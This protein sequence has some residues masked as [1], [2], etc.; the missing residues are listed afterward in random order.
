MFANPL[1]AP[2]P[3]V[4]VCPNGNTWHTTW[5]PHTPRMGIYA[6]LPHVSLP[7]MRLSVM[8]V[9]ASSTGGPCC[10][11]QNQTR[12]TSDVRR[13]SLCNNVINSNPQVAAPSSHAPQQPGIAWHDVII[14]L[15]T[16]TEQ[17]Q[18]GCVPKG[19]EGKSVQLARMCAGLCQ[20]GAVQR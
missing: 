1:L 11:M 19:P 5:S 16:G 8:T 18:V 15:C 20:R 9:L 13:Q 12:P 3:L 4:P 10:D 2:S 6:Q 14:V 7:G 17:H